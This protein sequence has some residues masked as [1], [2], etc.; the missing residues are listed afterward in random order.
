MGG[1]SRRRMRMPRGAR[2]RIDPGVRPL[3]PSRAPGVRY[4]VR[5]FPPLSQENQSVKIISNLYNAETGN[6]RKICRS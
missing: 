1:D 3:R 2:N 4:V 5:I 6:L